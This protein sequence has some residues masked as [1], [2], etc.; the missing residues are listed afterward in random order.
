MQFLFNILWVLIVI[1]AYLFG[2]DKGFQLGF[3]GKEKFKE[4]D[5][6][7]HREMRDWKD[8]TTSRQNGG[9]LSEKR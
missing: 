8:T 9:N 2:L 1:L 6:S 5:R 4:Y 3:K 7:L